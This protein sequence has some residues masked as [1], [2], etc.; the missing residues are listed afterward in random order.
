VPPTP[1]PAP[2]GRRIVAVSV[3]F[4]RRELVS[5][6][7]TALGRGSVLPDEILVV[8]NASTDDT[9][10]VLRAM[11]TPV[12]LTVI[13]LDHNS[14]GAGGFH[15]GLAAALERDAD[16]VWL[17]DDDGVPS[18]D[19]LELLL[20]H[21]AT[22]AGRGHDFVGPAVVAEHDPTRLCFPIRLPGRSTVVH[23]LADVERAA[24]DGLVPD[25]VI[26]FNGV[27]LTREL[28]ERIGL[29]RE[30]FFI[31]GDDVEYLW[32]ARRAGAR[33]ATVVAA[34]F[35]HPATDDL[36]TPMMFGRTT[37]NHTSSDLKHYCMCRNNVANLREYVGLHGV[38]AFL[39]KTLWFYTF[40]RRDPGRLRMSLGAMRA[41]WR[42]DFTGHGR[43]LG[44]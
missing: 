32:R 18:D 26:P 38:L 20:P 40:T 30:E 12:P 37:Y 31:W 22:S 33:I 6:V 21:M 15:A 8:D 36:G 5:R 23:R 39:V 2:T 4:N 42:G 16:L 14:G 25:V 11:D 35:R 24:R 10:E 43:Y 27:L 29:V 19:C 3:T 1:S 34:R 9:V 28:V 17:M 13:E 41:G 7:V 44:G